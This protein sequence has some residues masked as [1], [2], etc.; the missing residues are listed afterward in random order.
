[1]QE[2]P[3]PRCDHLIRFADFSAL[4]AD[5]ARCL[6]PTGLLAIAHSNFRFCDTPTA[7]AFE[8]VLHAPPGRTDSQTPLYGPDDHLLPVASYRELVFCK[9]F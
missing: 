1:L 6:K 2:G 7:T 5:F 4:V 9:H 3:A 8:V